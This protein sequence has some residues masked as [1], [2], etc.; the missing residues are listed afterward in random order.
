V[1]FLRAVNDKELKA[2]LG[3]SDSGVHL[4]IIPT[5]EGILKAC[6]NT[7]FN[8]LGPHADEVPLPP[9]Y[10]IAS[11]HIDRNLALKLGLSFLSDLVG[12]LEDEEPMEMKEDLITR[13]SS[14]LLSYTKEQAFMEFLANASDA[15][16]T[17]FGVTL[18]TTPHQ[19]PEN[20]QFISPNLEKLCRQ[21]TLLLHNDGLF[22]PS[23]W[24]GICS[25]GSG[26][27]QES[28]DGKLRIGRFGLGSL[29][30]FYFTEVFLFL[31]LNVLI[32]QMITGCNDFIRSSCPIHGSQEGISWKRSFMLQT[33][34]RANEEVC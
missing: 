4:S 15:G 1:A 34:P 21:P 27:K 33:I 23:D 24:K 19:L 26:Y 28:I 16:A 10:S 6:S 14:V 9:G 13:I 25:V 17:E 32:S 8:D 22:S 3:S 11:D 20:P 31:L 30:M 7:Y 2:V 18:A 5:T 29:S 12:T